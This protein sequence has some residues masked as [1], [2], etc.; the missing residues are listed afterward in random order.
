M[1]SVLVTGASRGIGLATCL[2]LGRAGEWTPID[3]GIEPGV[4]A[5]YAKLVS[6]AATGATTS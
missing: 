4:M 5:K 6:S 1:A 3:R 2:S